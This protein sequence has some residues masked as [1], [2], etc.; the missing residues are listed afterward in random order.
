M[1]PAACPSCRQTMSKHRFERVLGGEV[2]LDLCFPCQG[3]W[4]DE[5]ESLQITPGSIIS[6]FRLLH[7]HRDELRQPLN[8]PLRCPRCDD[9]LLHGIDMVKT[10][11]K[12]NYHRCL[13]KHGRFTTFGQFMI[14][15]GFVRQLNP[16]EIKTLAVQVGTIRCSGCGS[17]VDI[18]Q[19]SA[20][21]HC[22]APIA[23][24][25]AEAV[26]KALTRYQTAESE[27][28]TPAKPT[29]FAEVLIMQERE[30]SRRQRERGIDAGD[31][32]EAGDLLMS[33]VGFV[34]G[35]LKD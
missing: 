35:L 2:I 14:E 13:Q 8:E 18:R 31:A 12:F 33:G 29:L 4:F 26:E 10:G 9:R 22:A 27:R 11:G 5:H 3:I 32:V 7:E 1:K 24:L 28:T 34:L 17:A 30:K 21:S 16:A 23:T 15:K 19:Q 6:L 20:C 25:D